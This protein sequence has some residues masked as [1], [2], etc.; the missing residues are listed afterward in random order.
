MEKAVGEPA[1]VRALKPKRA[2][3]LRGLDILTES[4]HIVEDIATAL[5]LEKA[6]VE[7]RS[8][9]TIARSGTRTGIITIPN[10][11]TTEM[12]EGQKIRV[13]YVV[14]TI[15]ILPDIMRCYRCHRFGHA[16][17]GCTESRDGK[18]TCRRCR[19]KGHIMAECK[20]PTRCFLCAERK[21]PEARLGHSRVATM[22]PL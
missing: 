18:E 21:L 1:R 6:S 8:L 14:T 11:G 16:S 13:A 9:R 12:R 7:L 2:I 3:E 15:H 5:H 10:T 17:Y 20:A 22:R 19:T 4:I